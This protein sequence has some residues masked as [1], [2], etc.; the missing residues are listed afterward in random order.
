[1]APSEKKTSGGFEKDLGKLE[2][3]VT[4]LE[5]GGLTLDDSLKQFEEGIK[6]ARRCERALSDAE[7]KIELLMKKADGE[8]EAKPFGDEEDTA[9]DDA[10]P[11][12]E[13]EE[14]EEEGELLF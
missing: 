1:M 9:Q 7:K 8:V 3:I 2:E 11:E 10:P 13:D 4:A 5:E 6:L 14:G 12:D